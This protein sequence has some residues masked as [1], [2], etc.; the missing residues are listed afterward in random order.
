MIAGTL[1]TTLG[2]LFICP[3]AIRSFAAVGTRG[4]ISVR[5]ALRDVARTRAAPPRRSRR[6]A[7]VLVVAVAIVVVSAAARSRAGSGNLSD[8]QVLVRIGKP[9]EIAVPTS[10][11][12]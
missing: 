1:T 4:P 8:R 3:L 7:S 6:S 9:G 5:V 10:A 12:A 2:G 11:A